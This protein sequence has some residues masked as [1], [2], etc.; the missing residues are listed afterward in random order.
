[1]K[2]KRCQKKLTR[3]EEWRVIRYPELGKICEECRE[4]RFK[5]EWKKRTLKKNTAK[6][7]KSL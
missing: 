2:C 1:M 6:E 5:R 7:V 3:N 4:E